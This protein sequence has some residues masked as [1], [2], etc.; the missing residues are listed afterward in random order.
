MHIILLIEMK[1]LTSSNG[2][3]AR[4]LQSGEVEVARVGKCLLFKG[5]DCEEDRVCCGGEGRSEG[6]HCSDAEVKVPL[7]I[8]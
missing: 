5:L 8:Q 1:I 7:E 6:R 3:S 4:W 2:R